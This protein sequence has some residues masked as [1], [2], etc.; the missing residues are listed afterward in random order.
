MI[1]PRFTPFLLRLWLIVSLTVTPFVPFAGAQASGMGE[2]AMVA[3]MTMDHSQHTAAGDPA[4][5]SQLP[6]GNHQHD[7]CNGPCCAACAQC[8][9]LSV[10]PVANVSQARAA[11]TA[12]EPQQFSP[13]FLSL[14]E[15]PPRIFSV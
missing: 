10:I 4:G 15:R 11:L 2:Q 8:T 1:S 14:R 12:R 3:G 13:V 5:R 6:A 7:S 9:M